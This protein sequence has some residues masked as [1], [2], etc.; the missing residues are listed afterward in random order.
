MLALLY[1]P[2]KR[3]L[4]HLQ[5]VVVGVRYNRPQAVLDVAYVI[6]S[7]DYCYATFA[8]KETS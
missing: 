8:V 7:F 6:F 1:S 3:K 2:T 4:I 5:H